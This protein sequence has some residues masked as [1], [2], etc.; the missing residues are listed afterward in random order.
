MNKCKS[1]ILHHSLTKDSGTVSWDAI[2]KYHIEKM[3]FRDIG[4]HYG[5]ERVGSEYKIFKGREE[6][7]I[8]AH[9]R[10]QNS[11][12]IG[13]CMV[14]NFDIQSPPKEQLYKLIELIND[15]F[16]R[17]GNLPVF[18][19][20]LFAEYKT[21]PG[22]KFDMK[23]L[24]AN[25]NNDDILLVKA[26]D[27]LVDKGIINSP[28]YWINSDSYELD[29]FKLLINNFAKKDD[30]KKNIEWMHAIGIINSK[31]Y[32]LTSNT[33]DMNYCKLMIKKISMYV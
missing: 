17:H 15:I 25:L 27:K 33:F 14:G 18:T 22:T 20:H 2:R 1:I 29:Y 31:E 12:S 19:H 4:Y 7:E 11:T 23:W 16:K 28:D 3:G 21:C 30:F 5:I 13:I 6:N 24:L 10:G 26:V 9:T 32:W 8:G